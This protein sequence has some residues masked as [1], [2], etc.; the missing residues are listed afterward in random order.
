M[1]NIE[2]EIAEDLKEIQELKIDTRALVA[3]AKEMNDADKVPYENIHKECEHGLME[4]DYCQECDAD[5]IYQGDT[6]SEQMLNLSLRATEKLNRIIP[7][8]KNIDVNVSNNFRHDGLR[9]QITV[10]NREDKPN[11]KTFFFY[12][13]YNFE[14]NFEGMAKIIRAIEKDD[15]QLIEE[16]KKELRL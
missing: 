14:R 11:S 13:F 10:F 7:E 4:L 2:V 1:N 12:T 8:L 16:L 5:A 9:L 6:T 15:L 3:K